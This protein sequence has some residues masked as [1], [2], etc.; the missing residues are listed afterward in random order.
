MRAKRKRARENTK[1]RS[2]TRK[3]S[4]CKSRAKKNSVREPARLKTQKGGLG[5]I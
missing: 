1:G 4:P 5:K 2:K 3:G